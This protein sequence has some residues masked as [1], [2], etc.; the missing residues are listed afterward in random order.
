MTPTHYIQKGKDM[1]ETKLEEQKKSVL[2]NGKKETIY[3]RRAEENDTPWIIR[4]IKACYG[5]VCSDPAMYD[6]DSLRKRFRLPGFEI[7]VAETEGRIIAMENCCPREDFDGT[8]YLKNK[9]TDSKYR[10]CGIGSAVTK[11][12]MQHCDFTLW[13][14]VYAYALTYNSISQKSLIEYGFTMTGFAYNS[15][16]KSQDAA[17][18]EVNLPKRS[19]VIMVKNIGVRDVGILY[20][21]RELQPLAKQVYHNL[22]V[23][24]KADESVNMPAQ[25]EEYRQKFSQLH[26]NLE[27]WIEHPGTDL[28]SL[29]KEADCCYAK[30]PLFTHQVYLN[31]C[32][33]SA[34]WAYRKLVEQGFIFTGFKPLGQ[35]KEYM[36]L[37]D[38]PG[39]PVYPG[40]LCVHEQFTAMKCEFARFAEPKGR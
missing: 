27:T 37:Y 22:K 10:A 6:E 14:S 20:I 24:F 3:I 33:S 8:L 40:E 35:E 32:D 7:Y 4:L 31:M 39:V 36:V 17:G 15:F 34:V 18:T 21:P 26:E 13:N 25:K 29:K 11:Y 9:M 30:W 2:F 5:D 12:L 16:L 28:A 19:H 23:T 1:T 38:S